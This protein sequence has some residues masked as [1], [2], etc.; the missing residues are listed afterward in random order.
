MPHAIPRTH[1]AFFPHRTTVLWYCLEFVCMQ[2]F[3]CV[4]GPVNGSVLA[5]RVDG[6]NAGWFLRRNR[7]RYF[8]HTKICMEHT[9]GSR[10]DTQINKVE[11]FYKRS[12]SY[13][14]SK[15]LWINSSERKSKCLHEQLLWAETLNIFH[16]CTNGYHFWQVQKTGHRSQVTGDRS[17]K[18]QKT[19]Q[20]ESESDNKHNM[21]LA[22]SQSVCARVT[23]CDLS[24]V[25]AVSLRS[26]QLSIVHSGKWLSMFCE[27]KRINLW[28]WRFEG[29][30]APHQGDF[31]VW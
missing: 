1:A 2:V 25:P 23:T 26:G 18:I 27:T 7:S 14:D 28:N 24:F 30:E 21:N 4:R 20:C 9:N 22:R 11:L 5:T 8:S 3:E 31:C 6:K 19:T 10:L 17:Q 16:N 29:L 12:K 13:D 15:T